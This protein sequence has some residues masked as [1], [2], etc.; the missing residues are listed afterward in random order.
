M[1]HT[2][3]DGT[4]IYPSTITSAVGRINQM[5]TMEY[6]EHCPGKLKS[7]TIP[8][9]GSP[10]SQPKGQWTYDAFCR[11]ETVTRPGESSAY[12]QLSYFLGGPG[13]PTAVKIEQLEGIS[14]PASAISYVLTDPLG[15]PLEMRKDAVV[16][17][18]DVV[19]ATDTVTYDDRGNVA[20]RYT[21]FAA[22]DGDEDDPYPFTKAPDSAAVGATCFQ[23]DALGRVTQVTNPDGS[24]RTADHITV[25][26]QTTTKDE[27]FDDASCAGSKV[28]ETRDGGGHVIQKDVYDE[29]GLVTQTKSTY[30][31]LGRLTSTTQGNGSSWNTST[32]VRINYDT[33]GRKMSTT[34]PD[35]RDPLHQDQPGTWVYGYDNVGNMIYQDDPK[36][37]QY[38]LFCYDALSRTTI[39]API[40]SDLNSAFVGVIEAICAQDPSQLYLP[41]A[42]R[43]FYDVAAPGDPAVP[44]G[45]GRVTRVNDPSGSTIF[46]SYDERGHV[47]SMEKEIT[48]ED[49]TRSAPM[50]Y[51]YDVDHLKTVTY[52]DGEV[53]TY[54]YDHV[55][56]VTRLTGLT[57]G[58]QLV[59]LDNATYDVF[60]RP[61]AISH[62]NNTVDTRTYHDRSKDFRL[63]SLSTQSGGSTYIDLRYTAYT[64]TGLLT[65]VEDEE[66]SDS[67]VL[68]NDATYVYDGLGRLLTASRSFSGDYR[69]DYLGNITR[70]EGVDFGYNAAHPHMLE[71]AGSRTVSH[72]DNGNRFVKGD[73]TYTFD[74]EDRATHVAVNGSAGFEYVYDYSGVRV[75]K[76]NDP[77][78]VTRYYSDM[79]EVTDNV[80]TKYYF[81]G[82]LRIASWRVSPAPAGMA[83]LDPDPAVQLARTSTE[84]P[85]LVLLLRDDVQKGFALAAVLLCAGL[86]VAPGRRRRVVGIA[87]RRGHVILVLIAW[88]VGTLPLPV[89]LELSPPTRRWPAAVV[90][91]GRRRTCTTTS[92]TS[93]RRS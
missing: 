33:L 75:A 35:T 85:A 74:P 46:H 87:V 42:T 82:G 39:K 28:V 76:Y 43:Y 93:A 2:D 66:Y 1:T 29:S 84:H 19:L 89:G 9:F 54:E 12:Q 21:P 24:V 58:T 15:R 68:S 60:G 56:Q 6:D 65:N 14:P 20:C 37:S 45:V 31:A 50:S 23:Y 7:K 10:A 78:S 70:K 5:V 27:C 8:Y 81:A 91:V 32:T 11:P 51:T 34:D 13:T 64:K 41:G 72:D 38:V 59:H 61:I 92:I 30:D 44:F 48:V 3:Y 52:P 80:M 69:Y 55:G 36:D 26:Y 71:T 63:A 17:G 53:A 77:G 49:A 73:Q 83:A 18:Q 22:N 57:E 86:L 88:G 62:G 47:L 16:E 4:H 25:A 40:Q 90:A 67:D 79:V